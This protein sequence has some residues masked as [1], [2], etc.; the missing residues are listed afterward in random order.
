MI[1]EYNQ[2]LRWN[3]VCFWQGLSHSSPDEEFIL[4][5]DS[6][7]PEEW[8]SQEGREGKAEKGKDTGSERLT[9]EWGTVHPNMHS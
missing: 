2:G 7:Q 9:W 6:P 8:T 1:Y 4:P 3:S 5:N